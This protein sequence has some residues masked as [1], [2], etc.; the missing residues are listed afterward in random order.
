[1]ENKADFKGRV[2]EK[3]GPYE[4]RI[5][6]D[7][8]EKFCQAIG[9]VNRGEASPTFLTTFRRGE[10]DLFGKLG[11]NLSKVLHAEQEYRYEGKIITGDL[12]SYETELVQA[13][14]KSGASG[15]MHFL[16]FET[17]FK[18]TRGGTD[19]GQVASARTT[20]IART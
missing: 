19:V 13:L 3:A 5:S 17:G 20:I 10:F 18:V 7:H 16:I 2:G 11:L 9:S 4:E 6:A 15:A 12:V 8:L 1:M 14:R